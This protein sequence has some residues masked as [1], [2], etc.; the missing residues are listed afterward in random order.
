MKV[1]LLIFIF[2]WVEWN[3]VYGIQSTILA[4]LKR[5]EQSPGSHIPSKGKKHNIKRRSTFSHIGAK[6]F[7]PRKWKYFSSN[8][9]CLL[10]FYSKNMDFDWNFQWNEPK[11]SLCLGISKTNYRITIITYEQ[12]SEV[13]S[14]IFGIQSKDFDESFFMRITPFSGNA[15]VVKW[16]HIRNLHTLTKLSN[17]SGKDPP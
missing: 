1:F 13:R 15:E 9:T 3:V 16:I 4:D 2:A 8:H 10:F 12:I 11:K 7:L 6:Y 17:P 14:L 5:M